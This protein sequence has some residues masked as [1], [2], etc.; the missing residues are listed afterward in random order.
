MVETAVKLAETAQGLSS[1]VVAEAS[2]SDTQSVLDP[3]ILEEPLA[4]A[5]TEVV[6]TEILAADSSTEEEVRDV[7][8]VVSA[9]PEIAVAAPQQV[10]ASPDPPP[11]AAP[12]TKPVLWSAPPHAATE[13]QEPGQADQSHVPP[14]LRNLHKCWACGFPVSEG[15]KL[16]VE[17]EEKQWRGRL[18]VPVKAAVG[19]DVTV[20]GAAV[21]RVV[22]SNQALAAAAG[23]AALPR[24]DVFPAG[25]IKSETSIVASVA[26]A[27]IT[28]S[29]VAD[30]PE[31]QSAA[32][33]LSGGMESESW[34]SANKY[35]IGALF[36]VVI[37]VV[38]V[39]VL[40]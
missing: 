34:L 20:V 36:V 14:V 16:C 8:T 39:V 6:E 21:P 9:V 38:V 4:D 5:H 24:A 3:A 12:P 31:I 19:K 10:A 37:A 22:A 26:A 27:P 18:G 28:R 2:D 35:I 1:P 25:Q 40:R 13:M 30:T 23:V 15:R 32:P 17:C 33:V 7:A 11:K 29:A